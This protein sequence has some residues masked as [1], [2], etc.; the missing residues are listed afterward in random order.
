MNLIKYQCVNA[1][2]Q[3]ATALGTEQQIE[4]LRCGDEYLGRVAKHAATISGICIAA[5]CADLDVRE[6]NVRIGKYL[7]QVLQGPGEIALDVVV[8]RLQ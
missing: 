5:A 6:R 4:T 3:P 1:V 8:E 2:Q 7:C